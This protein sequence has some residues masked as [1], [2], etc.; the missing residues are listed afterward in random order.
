MHLREEN[1]G[2]KENTVLQSLTLKNVPGEISIVT[3]TNTHSCIRNVGYE[4]ISNMC[5]KSTESA[6]MKKKNSSV[7]C[8]FPLNI[9]ASQNQHFLQFLPVVSSGCQECK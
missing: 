3:K 4:S 2:P 6:K 1:P 7:S 5:L 9:N 8:S